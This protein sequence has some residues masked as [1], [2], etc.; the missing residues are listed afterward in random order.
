MKVKTQMLHRITHSSGPC[1]RETPS[2][3]TTRSS[4][5]EIHPARL[6]CGRATGNSCTEA[7]KKNTAS[8]EDGDLLFNLAE[9]IGETKNPAAANPGKLT[10]MKKILHNL[11]KNAVPSG[12]PLGKGGKPAASDEE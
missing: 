2:H 7:K 12:A 4:W 10:E 1:S 8:G 3:P 9:D 5:R 6:R 11:L